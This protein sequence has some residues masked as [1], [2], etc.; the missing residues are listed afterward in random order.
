M[1]NGVLSVSGERTYENSEDSGNGAR[2]L[3]RAFGSF[4]RRFTL[5]DTADADRIEAK[6]V[7]GVL[8]I[9]IPKKAKLQP[10]RIQVAA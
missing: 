2:R 3:E 1:E 9:S 6:S 10:K 4:H 5:P 8:E 7:H